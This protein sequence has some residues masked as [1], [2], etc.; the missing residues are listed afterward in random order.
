MKQ[1]VLFGA[2]GATGRAFLAQALG[3]CEVTAVVFRHALPLGLAADVRE[4]QGDVQDVAFVAKA[5]RGHEAVVST[6]GV[7]TPLHADPAVVAG[8]RNIVEAMER[9]GPRRLLYLSAFGV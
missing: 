2:S 5:L 7:S 1:I 9:E 8:V 3:R 4:I 6:L